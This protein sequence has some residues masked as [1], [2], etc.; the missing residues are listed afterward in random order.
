M[1]MRAKTIKSVISKKFNDWADSIDDDGVR[2]LVKNN[3]VITGGCIASMLLG[4]AVNDYDVYFK[5][6]ETASQVAKYYVR[7]FDGIDAFV[8]D[9]GDRVKVIVQSDGIAEEDPDAIREFNGDAMDDQEEDDGEKYRPVFISSNAITLSSKIQIVLRFY[10]E[11]D[12]LHENYDFAH[13][14]NH[15]QSYNGG[16]LTL[17]PESLEALLA[18]ELVYVGSKYPLCSIIRT[19]KFIGRG[20]KINAGQYLKMCFQLNEMDLTD[21][22]VLEEQLTGV[23][24]TYFKMLIENLKSK[25][26]EKV[27]GAY[28][29]ECIN[30]MF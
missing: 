10:G 23:D 5:N 13:C 27:D 30:R 1:G 20:W 9:E 3:T 7:K 11:P 26:H 22:D 18:K 8:D 16:I 2:E 25:G 4:E 24:V 12:K 14:M 6:K 15:W 28:L 29:T 17:R 21:F 19:R